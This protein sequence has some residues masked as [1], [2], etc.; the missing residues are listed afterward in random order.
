MNVLKIHNKRNGERKF[1]SL[2]VFT[3]FVI[4]N[5]EHMYF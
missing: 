2:A 5:G 1:L 3:I 4:F